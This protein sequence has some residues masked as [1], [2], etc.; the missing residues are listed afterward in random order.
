MMEV[1]DGHSKMMFI[2]CLFRKYSDKIICL[3]VRWIFRWIDN[4]KWFEN[5]LDKNKDVCIIFKMDVIWFKI[6]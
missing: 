6:L 2:W 5:L 3:D 1:I 4:K